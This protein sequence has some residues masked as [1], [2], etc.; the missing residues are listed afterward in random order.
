L[1]RDQIVEDGET[2]FYPWADGETHGR[3]VAVAIANPPLREHVLRVIATVKLKAVDFHSAR[4]LVRKLR[5]TNPSCIVLD[6]FLPDETGLEV[7]AALRDNASII[8]VASSGFGDVQTAVLAMKRGAV[9]F[10]VE[11]FR[12]QQLLDAVFDA[13]QLDSRSRR[14]RTAEEATRQRLRGLTARQR[15]VMELIVA[16]KL[17]K[18]IAEELRISEITGKA[19]RRH[20]LKKMNARGVVDLVHKAVLLGMLRFTG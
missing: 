20:V 1:A 6:V 13:F 8:F 17:I 18:E 19:H 5:K 16:G 11:P 12:D 3:T 9:D 15:Q 14:R 7:Q 10:L 2:L 4:E